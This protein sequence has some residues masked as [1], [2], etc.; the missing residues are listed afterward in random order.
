[1]LRRRPRNDCFGMMI[2][3]TPICLCLLESCKRERYNKRQCSTETRCADTFDSMYNCCATDQCDRGGIFS[4]R[5]ACVLACFFSHVFMTRWGMSWGQ[6][7]RVSA[8]QKGGFSDQAAQK[9]D[10]ALW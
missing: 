3:D 10:D 5:H 6:K 2:Q 9:D 4:L 8:A 7:A 1:V